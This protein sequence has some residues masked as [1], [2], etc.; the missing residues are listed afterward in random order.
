MLPT[1]RGIVAALSVCLL[2]F[3]GWIALE[4]KAKDKSRVK[5][6]IVYGTRNEWLPRLRARLRS[7]AN[8]SDWVAEG[9]QKC[10]TLNKPFYIPT[11]DHGE[12]VILPQQQIKTIYSLS[13]TVLDVHNV[14]NETMQMHYTFPDPL[15][16][17]DPLHIRVIRNQLTRNIPKL[18]PTVAE[19]ISWG[20][21]R[22]WGIDHEWKEVKV[23]DSALRV[24]AGAGNG[25]FC[26]RPL[27]RDTQYLERLKEHAIL[28]PAGAIGISCL[29]GP[30]K[31]IMGSI[32]SVASSLMGSR[33][34]RIS[35]PF[36]KDRLEKTAMLKKD[37]SYSWTPPD[38]AL[39]WMID[40]SYASDRSAENLDVDRVCLRLLIVNDVSLLT[41]AYTAQNLLLDIFSTDPS[42]GYVEQLRDECKSALAEAG[43]TWN[44]EAVKKLRL[45]DSAI[46]E[47]MRMNPFGSVALPRKVSSPDGIKL[48]G[49]SNRVPQ[50][51]YL[52]LPVEAIH[53]DET[54]YTNACQ[55][56]P[57]RFVSRREM[58][59]TATSKE[60]VKS[61]V[62]LDD[63]FMGFG[64]VGRNA[65]PGR[66]FAHLEVMI[67]IA[68]ALLEYDIEYLASRPQS[69]SM[70]WMRYP[71]DA[72][73]RVRKRL[74][75]TS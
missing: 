68:N 14:Q 18:V 75:D 73:I 53:F 36:V 22:G 26:G 70:M 43:G 3:I 31:K 33:V 71:S 59:D 13:E 69:L 60:Y 17:E 4:Y 35:R 32:L 50:G 6:Q 27:C 21:R 38:D 72:K 2:S 11:L 48:D 16:H 54:N 12:V 40:E 41:T 8:T 34:T 7:F 58:P 44:L 25:A 39:Q 63:T 20:F 5:D 9:Y 57:F 28:I 65:C 15:V 23:W 55:Y 74:V 46:R 67:F 30:L 24:V 29:P 49:W 47:S 61:T 1:T 56:D 66:F 64:V 62:T 45:I 10:S 42:H 52:A 51:T 37:P 19:E